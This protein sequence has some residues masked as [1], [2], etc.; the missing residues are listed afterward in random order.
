MH[1]CI[2]TPTT[3]SNTSTGMIWV[4]LNMPSAME[5]CHEPSGNRQ[6]I[7]HCLESRHPDNLN[8]DFTSR[9]V[10]QTLCEYTVKHTQMY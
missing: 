1:C 4:T 7:S 8:K 9:L 2:P 3:D 6:G 5:E 10:S